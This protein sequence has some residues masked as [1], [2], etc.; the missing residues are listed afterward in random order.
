[1]MRVLL[2]NPPDELELMLGV[3]KEFIQKFEPLGILYIAAWLREQGHRV[4][5]V[6]AY[7]ENLGR[8]DVLLRIAAASP[9]VVG[10]STLTC[11]GSLVFSI[12]RELK[13]RYPNIL[14]VLG[15][16]HASVFARQYLEN[17]CCD[18]VVH[19]DGELTMAA[20]LERIEHD[21]GLESVAGIAFRDGA[22]R[23]VENGSCTL[24]DLTTLPMPARDLVEQRAYGVDNISNQNFVP[25]HE[26]RAKTL[27]TSRGCPF[28]CTFCVVHGDHPSRYNSAERVVDE[29]EVLEKDYDASY[30][31]IQDPLFMG[32]RQ[33]LFAI[34]EEIRRRNLSIAW[35]CDTHVNY[36]DREVVTTLAGANC[37]ELS[38]GIE[39]GVQRLLDVVGKRTDLGRIREAARTV[40]RHSDILLEGLFIL[41]I[42]GETRKESLQTIRFAR[43]LPLDMAQFSVFMPYPGSIAFEDLATRGEIDTGVRDD[44]EVVPAVW[45][46]YSSYICFN[47]IDPI[48]VTPTQTAEQLRAL[49]KR[50]LRE[51]YLRPR[52]IWRQ[53]KRI[54][55]N[56]AVKMARI[57]LRGFF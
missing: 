30:V 56:N 41:G 14:V 33:R 18:V 6:D 22:G 15:N 38:I 19:G 13:R 46:R 8:D 24:P 10:F 21:Q 12:G 51:F 11:S 17:G 57:A 29:L 44:G 45:R 2:V 20:I 25:G 43:S 47:D 36:L 16:I 32:N 37:Y 55:P 34:C 9:D 52:P 50:A 49:Q 39:S 27:I 26:S 4:E 54:R 42:P 28:R 31:Y 48:W 35:G 53:I 7:A 3:G 5:V 1:M 23:V 40:K